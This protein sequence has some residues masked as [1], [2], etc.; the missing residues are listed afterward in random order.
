MIALRNLVE[1][2]AGEIACVAG[3]AGSDLLGSSA[4]TKAAARAQPFG[5]GS[6]PNRRCFDLR[7]GVIDDEQRLVL[8]H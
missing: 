2:P 1:A 7:R 4:A 6:I 3:F 8:I 5:R